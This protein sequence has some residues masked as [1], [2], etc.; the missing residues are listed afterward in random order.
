MYNNNNQE[1]HEVHLLRKGLTTRRVSQITRLKLRAKQLSV[2]RREIARR[3]R[4]LLNENY[5]LSQRGKICVNDRRGIE[6]G[7][8]CRE[9]IGPAH[10]CVNFSWS[11]KLCTEC[12]ECISW[13]VQEL[14]TTSNL[15][16]KTEQL[17]AS[18]L[19]QGKCP[20]NI[21]RR[22]SWTEPCIRCSEKIVNWRILGENI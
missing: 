20:G 14:K 6:A 9:R 7:S 18:L 4:N 19:E 2:V 15:T 13:V 5:S 12:C 21:R 8:H 1:H 3:F 10:F 11:Q 17:L 22:P 16:L